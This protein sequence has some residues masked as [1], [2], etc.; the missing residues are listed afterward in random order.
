[1]DNSKT[2]GY[3]RV[4][5]KGQ[6]L[7]RQKQAFLDFGIDPINM[8]FDIITGSTFDR[9]Q[10]NLLKQILREGDLLVIQSIDRLGRSYEKIVENYKIIVKDIK[11]D[12]VVLD[13]PLL[14]TRQNKDLLGTFISDLVLQLLSYVAQTEKEKINI[15]QKQG[16]DAAFK[17]KTTKTGRW[18]G[19]PRK[20]L[21]KNF[22]EL[23]PKWK[24]KEITSKEF[25]RQT[26][27]KPYVFY[28][29]IREYENKNN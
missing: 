4:S 12:L 14:D 18:F 20:V 16:I 23:Y 15:R 19:R 3:G 9:E 29:F 6:S 24:N 27:L 26:N 22:T 28:N 2:F 1:M 5:S 10:Y 13:M 21:P 7:E 25:M 17:T 11:A 8:Y